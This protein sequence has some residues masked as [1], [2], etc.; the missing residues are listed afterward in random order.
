MWT[1]AL[2]TIKRYKT[3]T[4]IG[5]NVPLTTPSTDTSASL[6]LLARNEVTF[7]C[8]VVATPRSNRN[9]GTSKEVKT[10]L[11]ILFLFITIEPNKFT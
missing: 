1:I 6:L 4:N 5:Y 10:L 2:I 11:I 9:V 8:F 3:P 7:F